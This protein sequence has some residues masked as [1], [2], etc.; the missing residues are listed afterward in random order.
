MNPTVIRTPAKINLFL[1]VTSKRID[2]YHG[3][4]SLFLPLADIADDLILR[5]G[6]QGVQ[7]DVSGLPVPG[8]PDNI[9]L[10]AALG[11]A[12]RAGVAARWHFDLVKRIPVAAGMGGGSSDAAAALRLLQN[13][14]NA[15]DAHEL[16]DLAVSVG[17]DVPFFLDPRPAVASG[18]GERITPLASPVVQPPVLIV[19]PRFPVSARWSYTHLNPGRIGEDKSDRIAK[20]CT[21]L[22][23]GDFY[24]ASRLLHNDLAEALYRKFPLLSVLKRFLIEHGAINVEI[25]G[26]GPTLFAI[27]ATA[28]VRDELMNSLEQSWTGTRLTLL[29]SGQ[30][31]NPAPRI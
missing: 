31:G 5:G 1:K 8:A 4:R 28:A 15:L 17:A 23:E 22:Q 18:I 14:Y 25:T 11:Y 24:A 10:R 21:A 9:V 7:I 20:L 2:G 12:E 30:T 29:P 13:R 27:C 26:S 6:E 19:N 3:I 16:V